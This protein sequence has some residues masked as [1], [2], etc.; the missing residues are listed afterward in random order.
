MNAF[1]DHIQQKL[2]EHQSPVPNDAWENI[3]REQERRRRFAFWWWLPILLLIGGGAYFTWNRLAN[4]NDKIAATKSA[5]GAGQA[6][7]LQ[8][9]PESNNRDV[10]VAPGALSPSP[11]QAPEKQ[12]NADLTTSKPAESQ[13]NQTRQPDQATRKANT[14]RR[15]T[16]GHLRASSHIPDVGELGAIDN[17]PKASALDASALSP[18]A[19][20]RIKR[21]GRQTGQV[22][23]ADVESITDIAEPVFSP[24]NSTEVADADQLISADFDLLV[25]EKKRKSGSSIQ[26][27]NLSI[28]TIQIHPRVAKPSDSSR[29]WLLDVMAASLMPMTSGSFNWTLN[30]NVETP[31]SRSS[32]QGKLL[33]T[34]RFPSL[35]FSIDVQ[36]FLLPKWRL[37]AGL[38]YTQGREDNTWLGEETK[39]TLTPVQRIVQ[40]SGVP[41]LVRDT[42]EVIE[43][44]TRRIAATSSYQLLSVPLFLEYDVLGGKKW[45]L[46]L[47]MGAYLHVYTK[48]NNSIPGN[49][50]I[51]DAAGQ[52]IQQDQQWGMD[53]FGGFKVSV[54]ATKRWRIFVAPAFRYNWQ[55]AGS[56]GAMK[57]QNNHLLSLGFG[58]SWS[59]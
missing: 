18:K 9:S 59:L 20:Q 44:G 58:A 10:P 2:N 17:Q 38:Q 33:S 19:K 53:W 47:D 8:A 48:Y 22:T 1:D 11:S 3:A 24:I 27:G 39:T 26:R 54:E 25:V 57:F 35:A 50:T 29:K 34:R 37:G 23:T 45:N 41:M 52:S 31:L 7:V 28:P 30:R 13:W 6:T 49:W 5:D 55:N 46:S 21:T 56:N 4:T 16:R 32:Y 36:R 43:T 12:S 15:S 51:T 40:L 14:I 42:V